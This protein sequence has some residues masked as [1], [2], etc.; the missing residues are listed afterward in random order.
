MNE[1]RLAESFDGR[2]Q[3]DLILAAVQDYGWEDLRPF[4]ESLRAVG[5]RGEVRFFVSGLSQTTIQHLRTAGV[6]ITHPARVRVKIAGRTFQPY[7]PLNTRF[8]RHLQ[9]RL[10]R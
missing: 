8:R 6:Q 3:P 5:F 1:A 7:T 4:V 2:E 9:P 10:H